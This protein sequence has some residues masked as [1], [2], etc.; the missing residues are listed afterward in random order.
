MAEVVFRPSRD[1]HMLLP[2]CKSSTCKLEAGKPELRVILWP[3]SAFE[4]SLGH[5]RPC[6]KTKRSNKPNP[7]ESDSAWAL[8]PQWKRVS[9]PI[10]S[11]SACRSIKTT[12]SIDFP[13]SWVLSRNLR[14]SVSCV[15]LERDKFDNKTV[16]FEEHI[17]EEHNMWHYLCFIVLVKVKDSTEY[18]GPESY[19]AEMIRVSEKKQGSHGSHCSIFLAQCLLLAPGEEALPKTYWWRCQC[20]V[21]LWSLGL[22]WTQPLSSCSQGGA[23][24]TWIDSRLSNSWGWGLNFRLFHLPA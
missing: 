20:S 13:V 15:G 7:D 16:T 22:I 18:T 24:E 4:A 17:Q 1:P 6:L 11:N 9:K 3:H 14:C 8:L 2:M 10:D 5:V 19:V 23:T 21:H 12:G